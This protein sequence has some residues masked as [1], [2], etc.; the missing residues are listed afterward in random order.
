MIRRLVWITIPWRRLRTRRVVRWGR[1]FEI[2]SRS[3]PAPSR[4]AK[5]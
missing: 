2:G 1:F 5:R 3:T 4:E